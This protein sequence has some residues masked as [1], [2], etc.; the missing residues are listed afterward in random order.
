MK[1]KEALAY[2]DG[3]ISATAPKGACGRKNGRA[4]WQALCRARAALEKQI[5]QETE[6][7]KSLL[8][9]VY[10]IR[11]CPVCGNADGLKSFCP[12]CGQRLKGAEK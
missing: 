10:G 11:S 9:G 2:L 1:D 6:V 4:F 7:N 12:Y 3:L 8:I 5:P